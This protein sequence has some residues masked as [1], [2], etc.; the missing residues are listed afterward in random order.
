LDNYFWEAIHRCLHGLVKKWEESRY[1]FYKES[2]AKSY[3]YHLLIS[4]ERFQRNYATKD[5]KN[6]CLVHTE[7]PSSRRFPID[8]AI[9][10]PHELNQRSFRRQKIACAIELKVWD[11][12]GYDAKK[13]RTIRDTIFDETTTSFVIY[14]ARGGNWEYFRSKFPEFKMAQEEIYL[15][16]EKAMA[17]VTRI[18]PNPR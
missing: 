7:Y 13:E 17:L 10:D 1:F 3:L 15:E 2:D 18:K 11:S 14:L 9:L 6:T 4:E 8:V 12:A 16:S 5:S